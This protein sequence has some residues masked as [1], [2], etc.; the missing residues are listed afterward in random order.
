MSTMSKQIV[1]ITILSTIV[2]SMKQNDIHTSRNGQLSI[3]IVDILE[4][5]HETRYFLVIYRL[6]HECFSLLDTLCLLS[7]IERIH[8][9]I[10]Q[11]DLNNCTDEVH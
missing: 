9:F 11:P 2:S 5:V 1:E 8:Q 10:D 6:F 7:I 4:C 3:I